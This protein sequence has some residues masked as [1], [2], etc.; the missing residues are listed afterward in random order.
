VSTNGK[1]GDKKVPDKIK[2]HGKGRYSVSQ[3]EILE[4]CLTQK[5]N[6]DEPLNISQFSANT[7]TGIKMI[8]N[9]FPQLNE[10]KHPFMFVKDVKSTI[11]KSEFMKDWYEHIDTKTSIEEN[12]KNEPEKSFYRHFHRF[13]DMEYANVFFDEHVKKESKKLSKYDD[14]CNSVK[15]WDS[16]IEEDFSLDM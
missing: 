10:Y 4:F 6:K 14:S 16:Q 1:I 11:M 12:K 5:I 7:E 8:I 9:I 15:N 3:K 13:L 2:L